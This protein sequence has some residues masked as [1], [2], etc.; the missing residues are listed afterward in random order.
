MRRAVIAVCYMRAGAWRWTGLALTAGADA[1]GCLRNRGCCHGGGGVPVWPSVAA[2][3]CMH[4]FILL[5]C[6]WRPRGRDW[7]H[8]CRNIAWWPS[9]F[10][11]AL[12]P[13]VTPQPERDG[14][15]STVW[16]VCF[17]PG[18]GSRGQGGARRALVVSWLPDLNVRVC[19]RRLFPPRP[20]RRWHAAHCCCGCACAGVRRQRWRPHALAERCVSAHAIPYLCV[21]VTADWR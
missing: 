5:F 2:A 20:P 3:P 18:A 11:H 6:I 14:Y 19:A 7:R 8:T 1:N 17:S 21:R 10:P 9:L 12:S 4:T 15:K 16:D 13:P